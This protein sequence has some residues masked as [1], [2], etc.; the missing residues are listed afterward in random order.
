MAARMGSEPARRRIR[1]NAAQGRRSDRR[2]ARARA[3]RSGV[4]IGIAPLVVNEQR[5]MSN[6]LSSAQRS[7]DNAAATAADKRAIENGLRNSEILVPI[8][9]SSAELSA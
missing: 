4:A 3:W 1:A 8:A 2:N 6:Q 5:A 7:S 9:A